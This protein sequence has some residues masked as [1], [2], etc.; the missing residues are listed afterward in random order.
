[1]IKTYH[2]SRN[3]SI[4]SRDIEHDLLWPFCQT[5]SN[6]GIETFIIF[7]TYSLV[8]CVSCLTLLRKQRRSTSSTAVLL[9]MKNS[10]IHSLSTS[11]DV[12]FS[13]IAFSQCV[14]RD[15]IYPRWEENQRLA[16]YG[17]FI[18]ILSSRIRKSMKFSCFYDSHIWKFLI[19]IKALWIS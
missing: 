15:Q 13:D 19:S 8:F 14:M 1:M 3:I 2:S 18:L 17:P 16:I 9:L 7:T 11:E 12:I 5:N 6:A 4:C 10:V